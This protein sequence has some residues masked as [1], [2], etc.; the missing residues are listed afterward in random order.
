[1][2]FA[3]V[4]GG[5]GGHIYPG[6]AIA[7]AIKERDPAA[8]IIFIG[9]SEGLEKNIIEQAGFDIRLIRSRGLL[10][11]ISYKA[12]SAPFVS[13]IG[14]FQAISL[15]YSYRPD[16]LLSTGGYA[17]LPAAI[18]AW[19]LRI[20][21][22]LQEQNTLPGAVNRF[23]ARLAKKCFLSFEETKKYIAGE[24]VGNPVRQEIIKAERGPARQKYAP[25]NE[26][27]ILVIGG[28]QGAKRL[29]EIIIDSLSHLPSGVKIVH[30]VGQRDFHWVEVKTQNISRSQYQPLA[31]LFDMSEILAAA[32]LVISRAGATAI[33]EFLVRGL[34]MVLVPFPYAADN[35]QLLNARAVANAGAAV[36]IEEKDLDAEKFIALL[37]DRSL[38][39]A[40]M[41][42]AAK[43]LAR[44]LAA[45]RIVDSLYG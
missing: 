15:L 41:S 14:F 19:I 33:A 31:Y 45:E 44:P 12:I 4:A 8:K 1:M 22:V 13:L 25:N 17:S 35:H 42:L 2:K 36:L 38:N 30:I 40:K 32:D 34:P 20:P 39:Y 9:S 18:A 43:S 24:C 10:R 11:K 28:S 29:N 27:L 16:Y 3:I 7:Q 21:I 26:K 6:L 23:V 5:T 37:N